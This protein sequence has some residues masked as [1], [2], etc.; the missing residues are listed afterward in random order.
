M[1]NEERIGRRALQQTSQEPPCQQT[2]H[3]HFF[4]L[5]AAKLGAVQRLVPILQQKSLLRVHCSRFCGRDAKCTIVKKMCASNKA[6]VR[7]TPDLIVAE[8][9]CF[10][11]GTQLVVQVPSCERYAAYRI[12]TRRQHQPCQVTA[13]TGPRANGGAYEKRPLR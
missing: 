13:C 9:M 10:T 1:P 11:N 4:Q 7:S 3:H 2:W 6:S 8:W 12:A 5:H